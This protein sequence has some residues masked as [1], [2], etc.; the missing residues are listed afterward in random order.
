M[1]DALWGKRRAR[2][3]HPSLGHRTSH[4]IGDKACSNERRMTPLRWPHTHRRVA[5]YQLHALVTIAGSIDDIG[6]LQV[7]V[8]V[9]EVL[10]VGMRKDRP[11]EVTPGRPGILG[12]RR[13]FIP[14]EAKRICG[15]PTG[16]AAI[17]QHGVELI[18][19][20]H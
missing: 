20:I 6:Y 18:D 9:D 1:G 16:A 14:F 19:A 4:R 2:R 3:G 12:C 13:L 7:L 10:A 11:R 8:V 5:F 17:R 15:Q